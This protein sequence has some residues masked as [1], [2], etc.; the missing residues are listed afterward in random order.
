MRI[1]LVGMLAGML[2][3]APLP[4]EAETLTLEDVLRL[5]EERSPSLRAADAR[6]READ[7]L[8]EQAGAFPNPELS[9]EAENFGG[10]GETREFDA[11]EKTLRLSEP[12]EIGKRSPRKKGAAAGAKIASFLRERTRLEIRREATVRFAEVLAAQERT[13]LAEE[14]AETAAN[15]HRAVASRVAAG[16]DSPVEENRARAELASAGLVMERARGDLDARRRFLAALWGGT[17]PAVP[18]TEDS[19]AGTPN[20][21]PSLDVLIEALSGSPEASRLDEEVRL[22]EASL[23]AERWGRV[24][25]LF[26]EGGVRESEADDRRTYVG[27]IG[28]ELPLF[29]RNGGNVSAAKARV[30]AAEADRD[31]ALASLRADLASLHAALLSARRALLVIEAEVLPAAKAAF[32][33]V[34]EGYAAGKFG[35][36]DLQDA[37]RTFVA[38]RAELVAARLEYRAAAADVDRMLGRSWKD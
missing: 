22:A 29:D 34:A 15:I 9:F 28:I 30:A 8:R 33:A 1:A 13:T 18:V 38:A 23:S 2:I 35:Y 32:D 36:L 6:A 4:A 3:F 20:E 17:D 31:A 5:V 11:A 27:A 14:A 26:V 25:D 24:P 16:R 10:T 37:R 12:I 21:V 19:P 7:G